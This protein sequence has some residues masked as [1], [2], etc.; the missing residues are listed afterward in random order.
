VLVKQHVDHLYVTVQDALA[1]EVLHS[2]RELMEDAAEGFLR[3]VGFV[4][5]VLVH[6]PLKVAVGGKFHDDVERL[7]LDKGSEVGDYVLVLEPPQ[8]QYFHQHLPLMLRRQLSALDLFEAIDFPVLPA[9]HLVHNAI[10]AAP[11]LRHHFKISQ[12]LARCVFI[13][14]PDLFSLN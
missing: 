11:E 14:G 7:F 13:H 8:H 9:S 4:A 5:L 10:R 2:L 6:H 12:T 3:N 1:M